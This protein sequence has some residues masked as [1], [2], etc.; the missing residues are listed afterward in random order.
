MGCGAEGPGPDDGV[1]QVLSQ[2]EKNKGHRT[3]CQEAFEPY[4]LCSQEPAEICSGCCFVIKEQECRETIRKSVIRG[5]R[6]VIPAAD[7]KIMSA[8]FRLRAHTLKP[9]QDNAAI[10]PRSVC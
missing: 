5:Q 9:N 10:S 3:Y 7:P 2:D 4:P 8:T 1:Q 6:Y